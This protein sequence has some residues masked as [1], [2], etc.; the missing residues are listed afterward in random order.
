MIAAGA[1]AGQAPIE[2]SVAL[3]CYNEEANLAGTIEDLR[4]WFDASGVSGEIIAV[5]DGSSDGTPR[6][7][8]ELAERIPELRIR[9]HGRNRGYG[10]AVR[11]G[12]D[13][14]R[15]EWIA[16]MD[17]DGQFRARDFGKLL[18]FAGEADVITGRRAKR[19]DSL[20]RSLNAAGFGLLNRL[21][22]GVRVRDI[23]CGMK[24]IRRSRWP[25]VRPRMARGATFNLELFARVKK[26]G[27]DWRQVLVD[28]YPR[29]AG[30]QTGAS[31]RVIGR[32]FLEMA[33]LWWDL[34]F[35]RRVE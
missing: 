15:G 24:M 29:T 35:E 14:G 27:M 31:P 17:S 6:I 34:W 33:R 7:L 30:V 11:T 5:D 23:N 9:R 16:F 26:Q 32:A 4:A 2:L 25:E 1:E 10:A 3:P 18:P 20:V 8:T 28:H 21:F 19:A 22:F 13:A 12:L